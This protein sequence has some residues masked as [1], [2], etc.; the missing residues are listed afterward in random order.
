MY[1]KSIELAGFKSF[2]DRTELEFVPG[3]AAVVGPNGSGKSNIT[4]AIR[5]ALGEQSAKTLR[6]AK[7]EDIIFAGSDTRKP[8]NYGEVSLTLNNTDRSLKM[9]YSEVTI[10]RRVY[11]SGDSEYYINKQACRLKDIT[12]LFMDTGLGREAYSII[13]QGR[14]EEIIS[15]KPEERRGIF[16]EASGIVKYKTR[17]K[18]A[19][20]KLDDTEQNLLRIDDLILELEGQLEPLEKQSEKAIQFKSLTESLK[21]KNI[22]VYVHD[23]EKVYQE[24][25]ETEQLQK[26]LSQEQLQMSSN[27]SQ[28][29]A[30]IEEKRWLAGQ[31]EKEIEELHQKLLEVSEE[32][33]KAEGKRE[34]LRERNKNQ[35]TI[36]TQTLQNIKILQ[37]KK[38]ELMNQWQAQ[39]QQLDNVTQEIKM[40]FQLLKHEEESLDYLLNNHHEKVE[41]LKEDYFELLNVM[42]SHR[43]EIRHLKNSKE[44]TEYRINKVQSE[45]YQVEKEL[46]QINEKKENAEKELDFF[47]KEIERLSQE[48][49]EKIHTQ[50]HIAEEIKEKL[51][52]I[53]QLQHKLESIRSRN[54]I[55]T[56]MQTDF[57]G[58]QYGVKEILKV[59]ERGQMPGIHGAIAELIQV[60]Q[61]YENA[62]EVV[63]GGALQFIVVDNDET[64]K[65]SIQYLKER[66]LGRATLLPLNVMKGKKISQF[67]LKKIESI[68]GFIGI[69]ADLIH[70]DEKYQSIREYL[71]GQVIVSSDLTAA[72]EI[73]KI[74]GY[75]YRIVTLDG[76]IVNAGGSMTGGSIQKKNTNLLSRQREI[77]ELT[78]QMKIIQSELEQKN[79]YLEKSKIKEK[80]IAESIET[81]RLEG[82]QQRNKEQELKT[83]WGQYN[84]EVKNLKERQFVLQ[85]EIDSMQ[86]EWNSW[87][88]SEQRIV[89]QLKEKEQQEIELKAEIEKAESIRQQDQSIKEE[90]SQKITQLKVELA[91]VQEQRDGI[92]HLVKRLEDDQNEVIQSIEQNQE[93]LV[94]LED[95]LG[96][97]Q[98]H[99]DDLIQEIQRLRDEKED[100]QRILNNQRK[101]RVKVLHEMESQEI[102]AKEIRKQLKFIEQQLHQVEVK[103][104]RLDVSLENLLSQLAQEYEM[105]Y[106]WAKDHV[107]HIENIEQIKNEVKQLK[108]KIQQLGEV[109]LGAIEEF[110]RISERYYFLSNQK[111]DLVE[112]KQI[113]YQVIA[114]MDLEMSS[115]FK[116]HFDAI[117]EQFQIVFVKLFGGGRADLVITNP[118]NLLETGIEIVAQPPGKKL[119]NLALLSGG[120]K[121]LTAI[122]L[123]FAILQIKP[124]PFCVLD[125]VE[126]ALD[127]ANVT[128]FAQY[129]KE[130]STDTQFIVVTHR[131]GTMEEA[132]VLYGVTMQESGVS[133]LV[134]V[135]LEENSRKMQLA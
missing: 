2:A 130:Y 92:S 90:S 105:S 15:S 76:D 72:G 5:W 97:D 34:V 46:T 128:R 94:E 67:E 112:A 27:V 104:S 69:A 21:D 20:K 132:D 49:K 36:Q 121:A 86:Q 43:N 79:V 44:S 19:K 37:V 75:H 82:E 57:A 48:Y 78:E 42:A 53:Q 32:V 63:L 101:S 66:K 14:I 108:E 40:L 107:Q 116:E 58:F 26:E 135:K 8:V 83:K 16:E 64:G 114:E 100:L 60:P 85:Q 91:R 70:S 77:E 93:I 127:E 22:Q 59:R 103:L 102:E 81:I 39:K 45:L 7:M 6:G 30:V 68:K 122:T 71:L 38:V 50:R 120:E 18:E 109:N 131:K 11:R 61:K 62:I 80:S 99:E 12:E 88:E 98:T 51:V 113:L 54:E 111:Q 96:H 1:L 124:V 17:K 123:L 87:V 29:H 125:E 23:I 106:E 133:R 31:M 28:F 4:D 115:R 33:E 65:K 55:L 126:A 118:E 129:L 74:V 35:K 119:Q 24:W 25:Q 56:E 52:E 84:Y 95:G 117:R 10:T 73:A 110:E 3:I 47:Q 134:S 41:H 9:D 89:T 13:G